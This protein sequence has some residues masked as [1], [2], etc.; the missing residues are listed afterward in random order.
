MAWRR[1]KS[2]T[3]P[4]PIVPAA[5]MAEEARGL[6]AAT[7]T[8]PL[9][10]ASAW[11]SWKYGNRD[12]Q[13]EAWRLYDII[14]EL[15]FLA[16]WI[17]DSVSQA[18]LYVTKIDE[19]GEEAGEVEDPAITRLGAAPLGTGAQRDD[20]LRL[21]GID[22]AVGGE[23]WFVGE[24]WLTDEPGK[25][26]V[27]SGSQIN[28]TG[29]D[30]NVRRPMAL[31]GGILTLRD[32]VDVLARGWRPHPNDIAQS[33][34]PARSAI[35]AL[36]EIELLTKREFAELESR[37]T[38]AGVWFLPESMD[39]PRG[40]GDPEGVGG[41]M[42]LLQKAAALNIQDQSNAG[43]LVPLMAT[44]PD[45][46]VE[47]LDK[48]QPINFWSELSDHIIQF[49]D[50]A[51]VRVAAAFEIP[52]ELLTGLGDSNHW[53]AWAVSEEGIKR[54]KPYLATIADTLT[55]GFLIPALESAKIPN[56]ERYAY[57]FDVAPLAVRPNRLTEALELWDR[58]LIKDEEA[59]KSG[60][61]TALQMPTE[62]ERLKML[63]FRA[64]SDNPQLLADP[65]IQAALGLTGPS[66]VTAGPA[67]PTP[68][69]E[70]EEAPVDG[71]PEEPA[72]T[73]DGDSAPPSPVS[74]RAVT[75]A[76]MDPAF[77]GAK[78]L[79]LRALEMAG[80]K[81]ATL[82]E[83][84]GRWS[85]TPR[86]ELHTRIGPITPDRADKVLAGAWTH[87]AVL[88]ANLGLDA[89]LLTAGLHVHARE[90]LCRG[91]AYQDD[92]LEPVVARI[93]R[94]R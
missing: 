38:G 6:T 91:L 80:G 31:G 54:I 76:S 49:K 63:V 19:N 73:G 7:A 9:G 13:I 8:I 42:A 2:K 64:V 41:F 12:W 15:R 94:G 47:H 88:A 71:P 61:F 18:R 1:P 28:R 32:G 37:L 5:A 53:S 79:T 85:D 24:E 26:F 27:L 92:L 81:L 58:F 66:L 57:A 21:A 25:W 78:L 33:D 35:P 83:R 4:R 51:I 74:S 62:G 86:H 90:L 45:Q 55:R 56:P 3:I 52:S 23:A 43:A 60:A 75:G 16:G 36:R 93:E 84:R 72:D 50:R 39:F 11:S 44:V 87:A 48:L 22:L 40:E 69:P 30:V 17:G 10:T 34:S 89:E 14:P 59:V 70:I 46:L 29:E 67:I 20:N 77:V 65:A 82:A 68:A